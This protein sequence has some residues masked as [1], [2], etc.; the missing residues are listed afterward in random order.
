M[1]ARYQGVP[2]GA[3]ALIP[4]LFCR[5]PAAAI[6]FCVHTFDAIDRGRRLGPDGEVVH[7]M[8]TIGPAMLMID[9]EWPTLPTRAPQPDGS[10]P[11]VIYVYVAD[12][13]RTVARALAAGARLLIPAQNQFWG[14]RIAWIVDPSGHVWTVA[15]RV[16]ETSAEERA[17]RWAD[18]RKPPGSGE[19]ASP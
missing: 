7:A 3:S 1:D 15:S 2:E 6:E 4:R 14:D 10:S 18:I 19:S 9:G 17:R 11:V 16:E 5:D 13:D 12:V 8:L